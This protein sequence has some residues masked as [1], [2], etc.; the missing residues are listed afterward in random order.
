[1]HLRQLNLFC[2]KNIEE[3]QLEFQNDIVCL[4][5]KNGSGKTSLLDAIHYLSFTRSAI[6]I[7]DAQNVKI[8]LNQFM[9]KGQFEMGTLDSQEKMRIKEV[10]C[11]FQIGQK[12]ILREDGQDCTK[13]SEHIGR[14]PVVLIAP[15]DI[16]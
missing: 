5:G 7:S 6:N 4:L 10:L 8:G 2:F 16:E 1:M 3:A 13:F 12:K 15:Q 14:F 11:S 9:I